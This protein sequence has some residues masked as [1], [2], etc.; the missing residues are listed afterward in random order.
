[1]VVAQLIERSLPTSE[2][3]GSNPVIVKLL[4]R[5]FNCLPAVNCIEKTKIEKKRPGMAHFLKKHNKQYDFLSLSTGGFNFM[6]WSETTVYTWTDFQLII[7][8]F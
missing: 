6:V 7:P 3:R 1:M 4:Y 2:V 5:T 8:H